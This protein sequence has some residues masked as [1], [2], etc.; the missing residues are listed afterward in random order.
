MPDLPLLFTDNIVIRAVRA[1]DLPGLE[2]G[3]VYTHYRHVFRETLED[4]QRGHRLML[5]RWRLAKWSGK[6][7]CS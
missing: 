6:C 2:W 5:V 4:A 3:G 7:L 1:D